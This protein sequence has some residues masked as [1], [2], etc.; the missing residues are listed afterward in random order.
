MQLGALTVNSPVVLAPMAGVTNEPFRRLCREYGAGLYVTEMITT[1]ALVERNPVA[2]RLIHH[3]PSERIRSIQLYGVDPETVGQAVAFLVDEDRV[4]HIDLNFGCPVPKVTRRGGGAALPWK[5][6][7]F[8]R[9]LTTAVQRAGTVPVTVKLRKGIDEQHLTYLEAGRIAEQ[10]GI[11]G[12]TLH[13]RTL[14]D[15]YSGH[16]DWPA[17]ARLKQEITSIPVLGN[18][19]IFEGEDGPRMVAETGCDG[20]VVGRGVQ[21][22]P[23]LFADLEAAFAG[24][25]ERMRPSL[26]QVGAAMYRHAELLVEFFGDET[27]GCRDFRKHV[28]WY[29]KGYPVGG[30]ARSAFTRIDT[31]TQLR[32]LLDGLADAPW[33]GAGA[34]GPRGRTTR[35]KRAVLPE[36]WLESRELDTAC[37]L[38]DAELD[39]SGG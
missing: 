35:A 14:Q 30:A 23:W 2:L 16:A 21:G 8:E 28:A 39:I 9:I 20:V 10:A 18:G 31:L 25:P 24:R 22:R 34:E 29:F 37:D 13:A 27:Y 4:D 7:L 11:A 6:D 15:Q 32:E 19:D 3:H 1:R 38:S 17:I 5:R 33:P 26:H 36:H 12:I